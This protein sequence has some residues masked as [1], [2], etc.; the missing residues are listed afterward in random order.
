M[1]SS[2]LVSD[3]NQIDRDY[4]IL[5]QLMI[6]FQ[7]RQTVNKSC[8]S[9]SLLGDDTNEEGSINVCEQLN[10]SQAG[11]CYDSAR[12]WS[13]W[14]AQHRTLSEGSCS[15]NRTNN[16]RTAKGG[17]E[18]TALFRDFAVLLDRSFASHNTTIWS[19]NHL[20]QSTF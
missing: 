15:C 8:V 14:L 10:D 19:D 2:P 7:N 18:L 3:N 9:R 16:I 6:A 20:V 12:R 11:S 17:A 4:F 13:V 5:H 1:V